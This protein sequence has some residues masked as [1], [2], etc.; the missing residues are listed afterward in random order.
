MLPTPILKEKIE[1]A[2]EGKNPFF[3]SLNS[4]LVAN[5]DKAIGIKQCESKNFMFRNL[6]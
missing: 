4:K 1:I 6:I 2:S 3:N 5:S